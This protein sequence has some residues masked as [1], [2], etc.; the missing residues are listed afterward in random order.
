MLSE[1]CYV[2]LVVGLVVVTFFNYNFDNRKETID[3]QTSKTKCNIGLN[4]VHSN[5]KLITADH[6][7]KCF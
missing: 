2:H 3:N 7:D 5:D 4:G 1:R 6:K